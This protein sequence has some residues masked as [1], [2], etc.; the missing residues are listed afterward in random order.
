MKADSGAKNKF[1]KKLLAVAIVIIIIVAAVVSWQIYWRSSNAQSKVILPALS[2]TLVGA[3]GQ[4]KTLDA[5]QLGALK[6]TT[7]NGGY[8]GEGKTYVGN[9]TGVPVLTLL[10]EVGG[11][12]SSNN[13]TFIG[14]D[15]YQVT[16]TYQQVQG[17]D[18]N[19]FNPTT[20]AAV[21]PTQPLTV[22]VAYDC[23][24]TILTPDKG[25]LSVAIVG[26]QGLYTNGY[27]WAYFL[28][29]IEVTPAPLVY[30]N[31]CE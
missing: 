28:V 29:K 4:Q 3:N 30:G 25:P 15:G 10:N 14:S 18:I 31:L 13:V 6:S 9:F 11:I 7:A 23:N 8:S 21:Q 26:P 19:T 22:I 2:L 12:S 5:N 17:Q 27:W 1:N 24:G 20:G 16:F